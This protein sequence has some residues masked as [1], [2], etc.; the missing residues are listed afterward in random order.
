MVPIYSVNQHSLMNA[1]CASIR[2]V[3]IADFATGVCFCSW[4]RG[5]PE[6]AREDIEKETGITL[7]I[8][9]LFQFGA[10]VK[11]FILEPEDFDV[12]QFS[13]AT[14]GDMA[15]ILMRASS[16]RQYD[17]LESCT[18]TLVSPTRT[19][20]SASHKPPK[21]EYFYLGNES[22]KLGMLNC[23]KYMDDTA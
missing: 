19:N 14:R 4:K 7:W 10:C 21:C 12:N 2:R 9:S 13:E 15:Q 6:I 1:V 5:V 23:H 16:V 3:C 18:N 8:K 22:Q 17:S 20:T 11:K